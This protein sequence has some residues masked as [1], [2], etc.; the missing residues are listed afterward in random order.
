MTSPFLEAIENDIRILK[1]IEVESLP[2]KRKL[3]ALA[4]RLGL[5]KPPPHPPSDE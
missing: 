4:L 5:P 2:V 1:Q 3:A